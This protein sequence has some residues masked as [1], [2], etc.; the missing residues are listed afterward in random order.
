MTTFEQHIRSFCEHLADARDAL[1]CFG[2]EDR[3]ADIESMLSREEFR[4]VALGRFKSGK[5]SLVNALLGEDIA[6]TDTLPCT[7]GVVEFVEGMPRAFQRWSG[8]RFQRS[9]RKAFEEAIGSASVKGHEASRWRVALP[10][11]WLVRGLALVDTPGTDEDTERLAV[12][13][14]ELKQADAAIVVV[15]ASQA[16]GNGEIDMVDE[17]RERVGLLLVVINRVDGLQT[18]EWEPVLEHARKRFGTIGLPPERVMLCSATG[19]TAGQAA[20]VNQVE[21]IRRAISEVLVQDIGGQRLANLQRLAIATL[22]KTKP[23][24]TRRVRQARKQKETTE[25]NRRDA[26]RATER[27]SKELDAVETRIQH[28]KRR[29]SKRAQAQIASEWPGIVSR[30]LD[31]RER[32]RSDYNPVFYPKKHATEIVECAQRDLENEFRTLIDSRIAPLIEGEISEF[33]DGLQQDS[34]RAIVRA[35]QVGVGTARSVRASLAKG[36]LSGSMDSVKEAGSDGAELAV[37]LN[38]LSRA[39]GGAI[40]ATIVA[41]L[42]LAFNPMTIVPVIVASLVI[43]IFTGPG[44]IRRM[45]RNKVAGKLK[46]ELLKPEG[47]R[48][49]TD[50][51]RLEVSASIESIGDQYRAELEK[52]IEQLTKREAALG[53][54]AAKARSK[55]DKTSADYDA[56]LSALTKMIELMEGE[57]KD[58]GRL[59]RAC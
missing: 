24:M 18:E 8:V 14:E 13:N 25:A 15:R 38:V 54:K 10:T 30:V 33:M 37:V 36:A 5:S 7:S 53:K 47:R 52:L 42:V 35:V 50:K 12:A 28:A 23:E 4:I 49:I 1:A 29:I 48:S 17:L 59:S 2:F 32:W 57:M 58:L 27:W 22:K 9:S 39:I 20:H 45:I 16:A 44:V 3:L 26:A 19:A 46:E 34:E 31:R 56:A 41:W 21:A 6:P 51:V 55:L 43:S 40:G 11:R